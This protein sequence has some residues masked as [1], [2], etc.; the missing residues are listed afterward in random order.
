MKKILLLSLLAFGA[1]QAIA[2]TYCT[3]SFADGCADGDQIDSFQIP[4][5]GFNHLNTGCSSAQYGDFT[6]QTITLS[7]GQDYPFTISHG[8]SGQMVKIWVDLNNDGVFTDAAPELVAMGTSSSIGG[9]DITSG[10]LSF[11]A[12]TPLGTHRLRVAT[13][14]YSDPEPCNTDGFG[15]AH[16]YT[17]TLA[18]APTCFAPTAL[19]MSGVTAYAANLA[20]TAS[21]TTP[22]VGYEYYL[23]TSSVAPTSSAVPTGSVATPSVSV[24]LSNLAPGTNYYVWVRSV[25]SATDKSIWSIGEDFTTLCGVVTPNFTYNFTGGIN[26]CWSEADTGTPAGTPTVGYSNWYETGFLN[27]GGSGAMAINLYTSTWAPSTFDSWIITPVFNLSAGGYRVKFD[28][29]LT[30]YGDTIAGSLG[31]DDLVQFVVSQDG[32]TT[33]TV[34][35][36]WNASSTIANTSTTY[37]Y[38]LTSYNNA[39]TKFG[40]YATNGA[41]GDAED[42]E[43]F[44]D[45]FVVEQSTL[46]THEAAVKKDLIKVYP[47]PF[48]NVLNIS[49]VSNVKSIAVTDVSGRTVKTYAKPEASLQLG[50][51]NSGLYF[52]ILSMKDGSRQTV[53]AIKK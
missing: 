50:D 12:A 11:P 42:V 46:A 33:W 40:F 49:D 19:T 21:S 35:Q 44:V 48:T 31:S 30:E 13:R 51:L 43:F 6:S 52:V 7:V 28:Y 26:D 27:N 39:N 8:Y 9:A 16:D 10:T 18:A 5:A 38:E 22:G 20:W 45:N 24:Q 14:Y 53:K 23:S 4:G 25:C 2:Q 36:T 41:V 1:S 34:L 37:T 17:L 47:N 29:G 32:G 15:E 3:P